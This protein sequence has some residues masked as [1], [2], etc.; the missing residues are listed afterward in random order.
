MLRSF[1]ALGI[2]PDVRRRLAAAQQ[3]LNAAKASVKWVPAAN[4]HLTL[5]F[6]GDI[7]EDRVPSIMGALAAAAQDIQPFDMRVRGLGAFPNLRRPRV[8]WAGVDEGSEQATQLAQAVEREFVSVG[9]EREKR[10]FSAHITLGRVRSAAG[11][12][13][14]AA[15]IEKQAGTDFGTVQVRGIVLMKSELRPSG[16]IYSVLDE[17]PLGR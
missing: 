13:A 7:A 3:E 9:L 12:S 17:L 14:L 8:V 1:V 15:L 11:V 2:G 10:H 16:A 5:K 6:L 4:L